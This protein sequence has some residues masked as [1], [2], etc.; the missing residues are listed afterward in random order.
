MVEPTLDDRKMDHP[1][2]AA[3]TEKKT[4][5]GWQAQYLCNILIKAFIVPNIGG[6]VMTS[7][8][9]CYAYLWVDPALECKR[10]PKLKSR[11]MVRE[12][13]G[14]TKVVQKSGQLLEAGKMISSGKC[15][16]MQCW[17]P[18]A[19]RWITAACAMARY[20]RGSPAR[21]IKEPGCKLHGILP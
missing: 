7:K 1:A 17:I 4:F 10:F 19:T 6:R 21:A 5:S 2:Q 12:L 20:M 16:P 8:L 13:L 14:R 11:R 9:G 15:R 18:S 3:R